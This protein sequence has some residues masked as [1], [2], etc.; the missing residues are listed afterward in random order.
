MFAKELVN[1]HGNKM[2][3]FFHVIPIF[4]P[5]SQNVN[6][7]QHHGVQRAEAAVCQITDLLNDKT[8]ASPLIMDHRLTPK[9]HKHHPPMQAHKYILVL[10]VLPEVSQ[11]LTLHHFGQV[12]CFLDMELF[13]LA[14]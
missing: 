11:S 5:V 6:K 7:P 9:N 4:L 2:Y 1:H 3:M 10:F 13:V 8:R 14:L 12:V